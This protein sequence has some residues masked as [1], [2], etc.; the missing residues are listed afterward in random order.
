MGKKKRPTN[1]DDD[2]SD[3]SGSGSD[4][5]ADEEYASPGALQMVAND[6]WRKIIDKQQLENA[7]SSHKM[8]ILFEILNEC[9]RVGDKCVI[10]STYVEVLNVVEYFMQQIDQRNGKAGLDSFVGPWR[11]NE[12]YYRLDGSTKKKQRHAM[13]NK[14]NDVNNKRTKLMLISAKAG[15]VGINLFGAN[16]LILLDTDWNPS[17][18]RK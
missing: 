13:I 9:K 14:F 8:I 3:D 18:D 10:F 12:D 4:I 16:R 7:A 6:W 17:V 1:D 2:D 11:K 5:S 15:G